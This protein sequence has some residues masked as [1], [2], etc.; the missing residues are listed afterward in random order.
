MCVG[1]IDQSRSLGL[2]TENNNRAINALD[3]L[4]RMFTDEH[5]RKR[6]LGLFARQII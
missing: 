1:E 5:K 2:V 4:I 3:L 6:G